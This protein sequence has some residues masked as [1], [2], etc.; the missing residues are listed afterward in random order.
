MNILNLYSLSIIPVVT[1]NN[2][3]SNKN[4]IILDNKEKAGVYRWTLLSSSKSYVGSSVNLGG[5]LRNYFNPVYISHITRKN[6]IINKALLKYGYSKFKLEI[7]EY[8]DPKDLVKK[9]QYYMDIL[10]PEYSQSA[11]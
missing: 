6:M 8:C 4:K 11:Y 10:N 3:F 7:L 9:E 1:Y 2:A 5:R